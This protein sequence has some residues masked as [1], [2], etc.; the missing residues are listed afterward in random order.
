MASQ[1]SANDL[2]PLEV[3]MNGLAM[4]PDPSYIVHV[5]VRLKR[6]STARVDFIKELILEHLSQDE[7][8]F[9]PSDV[10]GWESEPRLAQNVERISA[11][12]TCK[13]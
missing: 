5:E 3:T 6:K 8:I 13:L 10:T 2:E 9:V 12:E 7:T 4:D 1:L 11:C